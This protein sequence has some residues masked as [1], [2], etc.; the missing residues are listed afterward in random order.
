MIDMHCAD[1]TPYPQ[2]EL[3]KA[4]FLNTMIASECSRQVKTMDR[5]LYTIQ[6]LV[7]E[8]IGPLSQ[9]LEMVNDPEPQ[10]SNW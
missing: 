1:T 10:V 5:S 6:G 2:K 7:L 3:M 8:G 9:L 4:L